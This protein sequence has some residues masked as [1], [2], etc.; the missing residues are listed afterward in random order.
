M[1][2]VPATCPHCGNN[3]LNVPV[4]AWAIYQD[5]K[6]YILDLHEVVDDSAADFANCAKCG[7]EINLLCPEV[8]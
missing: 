2:T 5:G 6:Y 1:T 4:K 8:R 3:E 7:A